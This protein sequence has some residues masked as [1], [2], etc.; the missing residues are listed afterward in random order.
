MRKLIFV[1]V[2]LFWGCERRI[3]AATSE[4]TACNIMAPESK[5]TELR[6]QYKGDSASFSFGISFVGDNAIA[7]QGRLV[8]PGDCEQD[9]CG[10][11]RTLKGADPEIRDDANGTAFACLEYK[12]DEVRPVLLCLNIEDSATLHVTVPPCCGTDA[13]RSFLLRRIP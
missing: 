6:F 12:T 1:S 13:P 8:L 11:A 4:N 3:T 9:Y 7:Y 5:F 2:L 10:R